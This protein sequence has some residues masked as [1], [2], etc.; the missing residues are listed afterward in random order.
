MVVVDVV[1]VVNDRGGRGVELARKGDGVVWRYGV[2]VWCASFLKT[3]GS[4][5]KL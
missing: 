3:F 4:R 5:E 1:V 2:A